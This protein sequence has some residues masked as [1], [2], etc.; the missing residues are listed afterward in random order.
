MTEGDQAAA[1]G[2]ALGAGTE[3]DADRDRINEANGG[4]PVPMIEAT[5][6]AAPGGTTAGAAGGARKKDGVMIGS[7]RRCPR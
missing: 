5:G 4:D 2:E 6:G 3:N 7:A 1:A